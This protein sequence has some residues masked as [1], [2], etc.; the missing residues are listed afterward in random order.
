MKDNLL[1]QIWRT[2]VV[3]D[4]YGGIVFESLGRVKCV[5]VPGKVWSNR[6][7]AILE[8]LGGIF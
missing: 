1:P 4:L 3:G 2:P 8:I 7:A 6:L 5:C